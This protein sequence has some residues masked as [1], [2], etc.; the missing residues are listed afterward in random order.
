MIFANCVA[1]DNQLM[2]EKYKQ[3][4]L[5]IDM[6]KANLV[7]LFYFILFSTIFGV[8][9]FLLWMNTMAITTYKSFVADLGI[10]KSLII[11]GIIFLGVITHEL[12]HGITWAKFAKNGFKSISFG[13]NRKYLSP[14]CHCNEP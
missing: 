1:E 8:P 4:E 12:L 7:A 11:L 9:Y 10:S 5:T 3:E 6:A 14:Y 2:T 13:V